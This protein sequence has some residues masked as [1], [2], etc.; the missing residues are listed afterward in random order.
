[1]HTSR[2]MVTLLFILAGSVQA[3]VKFYRNNTH[4]KGAVVRGKHGHKNELNN[5]IKSRSSCGE[6]L[7]YLQEDPNITGAP[8]PNAQPKDNKNRKF[9]QKKQNSYFS[10]HTQW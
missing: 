7:K 10:R 4:P 2:L 6:I 8:N 9:K 3:K 1:M 5:A